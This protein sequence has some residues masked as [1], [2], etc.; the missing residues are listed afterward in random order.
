MEGQEGDD[1]CS[2]KQLENLGFGKNYQQVIILLCDLGKGADGRHMRKGQ[3]LELC[4]TL[5]WTLG[6]DGHEKGC[7]WLRR[8]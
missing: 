3:D 4:T 2:V 5:N 8:K 7:P 1:R 6:R